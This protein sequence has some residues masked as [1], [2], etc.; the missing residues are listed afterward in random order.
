MGYQQHE[1]IVMKLCLDMT[2]MPD[3]DFSISLFKCAI[4]RECVT[5]SACI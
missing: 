5:T 3:V 4:I 2:I 1:H